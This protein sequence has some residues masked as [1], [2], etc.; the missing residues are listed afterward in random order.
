MTLVIGIDEAGYGPNLGPLVIGG[1]VWEIEDEATTAATQFANLTDQV[2][3]DWRDGSGPPWGDS[4][5]VFS[6]KRNGASL[7]PLERG[8]LVAIIAQQVPLP[9]TAVDLLSLLGLS[10]PND[11]SRE[12]WN[13]LS[14]IR[15]P[16]VTVPTICQQQ[17]DTVLARC[18][19][20]GIR[21]VGM[22]CR[23]ILPEAFNASLD[24]GHNKSDILSERSLNLAAD[25][26]Q[27]QSA[28][29][30]IIWCDRHGG[31][32]R[33]AAVVSHCFGAARVEPVSETVKRSHYLIHDH[34]FGR[35]SSRQ[36]TTS[37]SFS[38]GGE[39]ML[40]VAVASM[41]AKYVRELAM[42]AFNQFWTAQQP[43]LLPTAGY[44]VD[45]RR[46]WQDT[47]SRREQLGLADRAL[48]RRA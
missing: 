47:V 4:K 7:E 19:K 31:R 38:V 34:G 13:E 10:L 26:R 6:R 12:C 45:A 32:K 37:I 48:W 41:T 11:A 15:L 5:K 39:S 28:S 27:Q 14:T 24:A 33:Y 46:W 44:P 8:V 40:P 25:L 21:L 16:Q 30:A 17:A 1:S 18:E 2:T 22:T 20:Q 3:T 36:P 42:G 9:A 23:W 43:G 35:L 29:D